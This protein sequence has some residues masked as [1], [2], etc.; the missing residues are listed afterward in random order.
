MVLPLYLA[1]TVSE[2]RPVPYSALL[3]LDGM[4]LPPDGVLPV[5]TDRFPPDGQALSRLCHG[6]EAVLLDFEHPPT[7][8]VRDMVKSLS[9]PCAAPPGYGDGLVFLPP[10]PLHVPLAQYLAPYRSRKIWLEAA[11]QRQA[12]TVTADGVTIGPPLPNHS[13]E[14]GFYDEKLCC[15]FTQEFT[16]DTA[17]FTLFDTP[18]TLVSKLDHA[19]ALGVTRAVGLYQELGRYY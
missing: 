7:P 17:V 4:E 11:L 10:A 3:M 16:E 2:F 13:F 1:M 14:G 9:C 18:E 15:R 19:A 12:V 8:A 6:R 5:V